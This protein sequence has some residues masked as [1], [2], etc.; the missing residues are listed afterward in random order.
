MIKKVNRNF[1]RKKRHE[2]VRRK[3][4]GTPSKPRLNVYRSGKHMY[5][6]II[7]DIS[8]ITL[9]SASTLDKSFNLTST[10]NIE[11]AKF[12]G[13]EIAKKALEKGIEEVKFDRGGF[14]YHGR[15]KELAEAAREAGLKF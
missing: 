10:S 12:V 14:L 13:E 5:A 7:D 1:N 6:Q 2:R 3:I 4:T 8:A 9:T 11:A 15:I